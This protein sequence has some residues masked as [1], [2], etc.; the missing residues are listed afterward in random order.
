MV[1]SGIFF[2]LT[3]VA[4]LIFLIP[5]I[6][7]LSYF[8][9]GYTHANFL[10]PTFILVLFI[11]SVLAGVWALATLLFYA[12]AKHNGYLLAFVDICI[13][14]GLI[15]GVVELAPITNQSCGNFNTASPLYV[16]LY[17]FDYSISK[18]CNMLKACFALAIIEIL[19]FFW[20]AV[21]RRT[22]SSFWS[23]HVADLGLFSW[24]ASGS[25]TTIAATWSVSAQ[26][27]RSTPRGIPI[28][29]EIE[30]A[31][32]PLRI[33]NIAATRADGAHHDLRRV[34][35]MAGVEGDN[36]SRTMYNSKAL[37]RQS[38]EGN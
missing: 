31:V 12:I 23:W 25:T 11:V 17:V 35:I 4:Q 3:R 9:N 30:A 10:T 37:K 29:G 14:G 16:Q 38:Q 18:T 34:R 15:A 1:L 21:S 36:S 7:M 19:M 27:W 22:R 24:S 8:V 6:G 28:G 2:V 32:G 5:I 33:K 13:F 26:R 20:S